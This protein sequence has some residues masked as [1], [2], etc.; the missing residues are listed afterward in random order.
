MRCSP[1][2]RLPQAARSAGFTI[3]EL[4][5]S[6]SILGLLIALLMPA[7]QSTRESARKATC[8]NH[9][10]QFGLAIHAFEATHKEYPRAA[11]PAK[12]HQKIVM[13]NQSVN[14]GDALFGYSTHAQ[15]LSHLD[16]APIANQLD[17]Q[18]WARSADDARTSPA[19]DIAR[20]IP[21]FQCPSEGAE[22][23][24]SYRSCTG[25]A[26]TD[27]YHKPGR[28]I[29][30]RSK[31]TGVAHV[32]DGTSQTVMM[33]EKL[34]GGGV[35]GHFETQRDF[36]YTGV[37]PLISNPE[38]Q[39]VPAAEML[40]YCGAFSNP[41][42]SYPFSGYDWMMHGHVH[43]AYNHVAGP[44]AM[45]PDC[46]GEVATPSASAPGILHNTSD[47]S[48]LS[49]FRASSAHTGGV[50][51]LYADGSV[52]FVSDQVDIAVWQASA[53]IDLQD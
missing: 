4:L 49:S 39:L 40:G 37:T 7:V 26:P 14:F 28:G 29:F 35:P 30:A 9:L 25:P 43:T 50:F 51:V 8:H 52:R 34:H 41:A 31:R 22:W 21:V 20:T 38:F 45:I 48:S 5:V 36:W 23:G 1:L 6:I 10:H 11:G 46:S 2:T 19:Q 33:S 16:L 42:T 15:L 44:N 32:T 12:P 53:S 17:F 13:S 27:V 3:V 24:T 47:T 18:Q